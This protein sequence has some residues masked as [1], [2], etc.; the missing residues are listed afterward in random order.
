MKVVLAVLVTA[1]ASAGPAFAQVEVSG[2]WRA[3]LHED[4]GHRLDEAGAAPGISGAGGPWVGDFTGLPI[5]DAARLKAESWDARLYSSAEHQT[6]LQPGAYWTLSPG[7]IRISTVIDDATEGIVAY[8]IFRAGLAGSTS[9]VIWMDGRPHPP[10]HAAHTW[11]GFSTGAWAAGVLTVTTPHLKAGFIRRNGAPASDRATVTEYFV[12]RGGILTNFR[13]VDDPL[14]LDEPF[15][16]SISWQID[17]LLQ[18]PRVPPSTIVNEIP[19]QPEVFVPHHLPGANSQ[20]REF[21][22]AFHL[23]FEAT[24]GGK[25]TM[26]PEYQRTLKALIAA[27]QKTGTR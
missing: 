4:I 20:L 26:Y 12:R 14:Y 24:R 22:E 1:V 17:P 2:H 8:N 11:Q 16:S 13:I 15:V 7:G 25:E 23:P 18:L 3:I 27:R 6:I 9:R 10:A 5:N 19:G 21:A